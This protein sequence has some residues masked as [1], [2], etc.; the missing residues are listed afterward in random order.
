MGELRL[1]GLATGIDTAAL[2]KQLMI[3]NSRRLAT[4]Q[5][6]KT[7]YEAQNTALSELR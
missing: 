2:V 1:P 7:D 4:Y 5:V 3:I 6:Q